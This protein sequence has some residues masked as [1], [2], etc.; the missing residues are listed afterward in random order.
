MT[1]SVFIFALLSALLPTAIHAHMQLNSPPPFGAENNPH[2]TDP[3]D[4]HL[5][6][7]YNCCGRTSTY[8]CNGYLRLLGTPQGAPVASWAAGS[9]QNFSLTGIGNHYG[10]SCQTSFSVD[11]GKTFRVATS[12]EGNCPHRNGGESPDGQTFPF[13]VPQDTPAGDAVFAWTWLNREREFFMNCAAVTITPNAGGGG[14]G[15]GA[16]AV[17]ASVAAPAPSAK[18]SAYT[19]PQGCTCTCPAA[20]LAPPPAMKHKRHPHARRDAAAAPKVAFAQ[21]PGPLVANDGNGCQ[22]P[23][24][25]AE[26]KF[27]NPGPDVVTGDGTYPLALPGPDDKCGV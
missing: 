18:P 22:T 14:G 20:N 5:Q 7:P 25:T 27:P 3:A 12:Y 21:R 13:T 24:T 10:G 23:H 6:Y 26:V 9:T 1:P 17:F 19:D 16:G 11:G 8:P 4:P 2:R 15:E